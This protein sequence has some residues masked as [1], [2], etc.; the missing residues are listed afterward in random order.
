MTL[1]E[2]ITN[3]ELFTDEQLSTTNYISAANRAI[4]LIN[5]DCKSSF[6]VFEND[7]DSYTDI[8]R[9]WLFSLLS[10]YLSYTIK[11]NDGSMKE[12]DRYLDEFYKFLTNFK[13]SLGTLVAIYEDGDIV[14]GIDPNKM[15]SIG[16]GG[17]YE[18]DT[19]N[20]IN[21]GYFNN[22]SNGGSW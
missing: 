13:D 17:V 2:I 21:I 12:A 14:R 7:V 8:P 3:S 5:T 20:A 15:T 10:P 16:F 18:I 11:M 6:S 4:A 22:N 9:D 1:K 19:A